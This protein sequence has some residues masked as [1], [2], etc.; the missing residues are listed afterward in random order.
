MLTNAFWKVV[1]NY[2]P[3]MRLEYLKDQVDICKMNAK[4]TFTRSVIGIAMPCAPRSSKY[5]EEEK[6]VA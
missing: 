2:R 4:L 3:G 6:V 5:G 1:R